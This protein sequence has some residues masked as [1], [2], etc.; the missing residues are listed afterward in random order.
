MISRQIEKRRVRRQPERQ[1]VEL[2]KVKIHAGLESSLDSRVGCRRQ[3]YRDFVAGA[4][5]TPGPP[6][7]LTPFTELK[8]LFQ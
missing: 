7:F 5:N 1:L 2:E 3:V 6:G 8:Q 4:Q